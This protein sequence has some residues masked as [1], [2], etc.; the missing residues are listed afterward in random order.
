MREA[1]GSR[2]PFRNFDVRHNSSNELSIEGYCSTAPNRVIDYTTGV[3][4]Q[5]FVS[6][7][8]QPGPELTGQCPF[9]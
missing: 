8:R 7:G 5:Q 2:P 4:L 6:G 3:T 9:L 1:V